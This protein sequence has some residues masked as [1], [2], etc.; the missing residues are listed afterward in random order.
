MIIIYFLLLYA[1]Y[2]SSQVA[3]L[4]FNATE[5]D[6]GQ[7]NESVEPLIAEFE[8]TNLD[9][10]PLIIKEVQSSCGC[11]VIDW[12]KDSIK[13]GKTGKIRVQYKTNNRPGP[14]AK[15]FMV[16]TNTRPE[17]HTLIIKGIVIPNEIPTELKFSQKIGNLGFE[18]KTITLGTIKTNQ[19]IEKEI[20]IYNYGETPI[21]IKNWSDYEHISMNFSN[22]I[23]E[24]KKTIKLK[25]KYFPAKKKDYGFVNDLVVIETNDHV[26]PQK[27]LNII[28]T[29]EEYF[30][31]FS[32]IELALQPKLILLKEE[33][34]LGKIKKGDTKTVSVALKNAGK[35]PLKILHIKPS[36]S[37]IT[38]GIDK[39]ILN[40]LETINLNIVLNTEGLDG[41]QNKS[42]TLYSND[43][44]NHVKKIVIKSDIIK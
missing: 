43:P 24:S 12:T 41:I 23:I 2:A 7:I 10:N 22:L 42:V 4:R 13:L 8:V 39:Q 6:F 37:C 25:I 38:A 9:K 36:C 11:E 29:I 14:F 35:K 19:Q 5:I 18:S 31:E 15:S 34:N 26:E 33:I 3:T 21:V 32:L 16:L 44:L 28:A 17:I 30:P 20:E 27:R 1:F 40:P